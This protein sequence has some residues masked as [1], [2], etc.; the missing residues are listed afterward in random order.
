M[1]LLDAPVTPVTVA[2]TFRRPFRPAL[3]FTVRTGLILLVVFT[4]I[5]V[6][7]VLQANLTGSYQA[8]G[9]IFVVMAL[10][11]LIVLTKEGR[12][13]IGLVRP[14]RWR[15]VPVALVAGAACAA[16]VY[17]LGTV[18]YGAQIENPFVYISRSYAAV[19]TDLSEQSRL[20][21]FV[22]FAAIGMTYSPI[23]EELFYRG[24]VHESLATSWGS[25][26]AA[27]T[28]AGAFALAHL[29]HFG[30]IYVGGVWALLPFPALLW[31][32]AMFGSALVFYGFR[33]LSGSLLGAILAHA[34]FNLVM[35]FIIFYVIL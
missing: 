34:G 24:L 5:R 7:L 19:P 14:S 31:V 9:A 32:A 27:L 10:L 8:T 13:R 16:A 29:A 28:E 15:W 25:R 6:V 11:P 1:D 17:T 21:F 30:I 4:V 33:V 22:I 12:R 18:M 23:G 20:I 26:R 3:A 35:N 2:H